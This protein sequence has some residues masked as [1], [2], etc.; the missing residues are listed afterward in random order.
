MIALEALSARIPRLHH[1]FGGQHVDGVIGH[2]HDELAESLGFNGVDAGQG[3]LL[4]G[5]P[6]GWLP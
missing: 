6:R 2:A 4:H 3:T 1:A 5:H